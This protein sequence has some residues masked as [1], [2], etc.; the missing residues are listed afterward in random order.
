[1]SS[2]S[3]I[4][5]PTSGGSMEMRSIKARCTN[6]K[7]VILT[8]PMVNEEIIELVAL[9]HKLEVKVTI[10]KTGKLLI[11]KCDDLEEV[12]EILQEFGLIEYIGSLREIIDWKIISDTTGNNT[13]VIK[14]KPKKGD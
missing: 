6:T 1:M 9:A 8:E 11:F 10:S 3:K 7:E 14:F 13:Q 12:F 2:R 4:T 5:F